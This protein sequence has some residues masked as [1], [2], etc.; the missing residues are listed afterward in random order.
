M[1]PD[2]V[3]E[4][5]AHYYPTL[6]CRQLAVGWSFW[7]GGDRIARV[8]QQYA[9]GVLVFKPAQSALAAGNRNYIVPIT[10]GTQQVRQLIDQEVALLQS[11]R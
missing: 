5:V 2:D 11:R 8:S 3:K 4:F 6:R 1:S 10:N 7:L 9:G